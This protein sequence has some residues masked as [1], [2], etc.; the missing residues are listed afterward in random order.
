MTYNLRY[1]TEEDV[2]TVFWPEMPVEVCVSYIRDAYAKYLS[3]SPVPT[4]A[5]AVTPP[6][7]EV[8][9]V[10][11]AAQV[12]DDLGFPVK[13]WQYWVSILSPNSRVAP[14]GQW[15]AGF[16]HTHHWENGRTLIQ[17]V[18]VA[19]HDGELAVIIDDVEH[20]VVPQVGMGAIV[21]GTTSHGVKTIRGS[22]DRM[23][24]IATAFGAD[25]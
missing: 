18:Q 1:T 4:G 21:D 17:Y 15:M 2:R 5:K 20:T 23:T 14:N 9:F 8:G 10:D 7:P 13:G 11:Y 12:F 3:M 16:P 19:D 25:P 22:T 24:L 6:P